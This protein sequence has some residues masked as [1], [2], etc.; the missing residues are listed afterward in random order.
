MHCLTQGSDDQF[1]DRTILL[2]DIHTIHS[3]DCHCQKYAD[4]FV[5]IA[6]LTNCNLTENLTALSDVQFPINLAF[7]SEFFDDDQLA[8][9][10]ADSL[11]NHFDYSED[12]IYVRSF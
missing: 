6:D 10:S 7:L 12:V 5:I 9:I 11:L 1:V 2:S 8:N 4:E 3:F